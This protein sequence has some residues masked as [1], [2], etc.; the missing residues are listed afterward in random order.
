MP[1]SSFPPGGLHGANIT[2]S[3]A[4]ALMAGRGHC[5]VTEALQTILSCCLWAGILS[6]GHSS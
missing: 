3:H 5:D 1:D 4:V 6:W 2:T